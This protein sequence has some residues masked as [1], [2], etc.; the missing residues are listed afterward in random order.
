MRCQIKTM[1]TPEIRARCNGELFCTSCIDWVSKEMTRGRSAPKKKMAEREIL[2]YLRKPVKKK[3]KRV[4]SV[5]KS[6]G[7]T[8][9]KQPSP[10]HV[11]FKVI[12][13]DS[14]GT[15]EEIDMYCRNEHEIRALLELWN[16][17]ADG[18]SY[19]LASDTKIEPVKPLKLAVVAP[20]K[21]SNKA[22]STAS[23]LEL[24]IYPRDL[25]KAE[26]LVF[27]H[28]GK[29]PGS[30]KE[31]EWFITPVGRIARASKDLLCG[32]LR[33]GL[34]VVKKPCST[35]SE[36]QERYVNRYRGLSKN[37][38][39]D[40]PVCATSTAEAEGFEF[41]PKSEG[42]VRINA[43]DWF[44]AMADNKIQKALSDFGLNDLRFTVRPVQL[45]RTDARSVFEYGTVSHDELIE[46]SGRHSNRHV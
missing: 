12:M 27:Y 21:R 10:D 13:Q 29:V 32:S 33:Y 25:K 38:V 16:T 3:D 23:A 34:S 40:L 7:I 2:E 31:G 5:H 6:E 14:V 45:I 11:M 30:V 39:I 37:A 43:G 8:W 44:I 35:M 9:A 17:A 19:K 1:D 41:I 46:K 4:Y 36:M 24:N 28:N 15:C 26:G 22:Q 42:P 18:Y 20:G